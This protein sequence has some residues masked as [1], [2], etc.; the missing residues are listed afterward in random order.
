MSINIKREEEAYD[1]IDKMVAEMTE[2]G[3]LDEH[4]FLTM[5]DLNNRIKPNIDKYYEFC[6]F[7]L[8]T[9]KPVT[10]DERAVFKEL[11]DYIKSLQVDE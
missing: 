9:Q 6:L 10:I 2:K 7:I 3:T 8:E 4:W 5:D 11:N 1:K